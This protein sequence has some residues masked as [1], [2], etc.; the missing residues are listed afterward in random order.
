M[1]TIILGL[2][3]SIGMGKTTTSLLFKFQGIPVF[4]SDKTVH[5]LISSDLKTINEISSIFPLSII[6]GKID[7]KKL[8]NEV[9]NNEKKLKKLENILHPLVRIKRDAFIKKSITNRFPIVLLDIPLL[10]ETNTYKLCDYTVVVTAPFFIQKSRVLKREGMTCE[11]FYKILDKQ[12]DDSIKRKKADYI[13][14]SNM[15]RHTAIKKVKLIIKN[16]SNRNN[17]NYVRSS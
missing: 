11:K 9:F 7:K 4:D 12:L 5:Q 14:F 13:I 3:G 17:F 6:H 15:G 2:T 16:I 10:F 1:K 8:G